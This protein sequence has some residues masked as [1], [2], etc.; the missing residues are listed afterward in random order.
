MESSL[1]GEQRRGD[2]QGHGLPR[3]A[4]NDGEGS[5]LLA[6]TDGVIASESKQ[7]MRYAGLP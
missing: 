7:S 3:C 1:R 5:V 2:P 6:M 4:R